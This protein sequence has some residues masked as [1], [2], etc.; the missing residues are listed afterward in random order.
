VADRPTQ[1]V[2]RVGAR[3]AAEP[4]EDAVL[5][6]AVFEVGREMQAA[7]CCLYDFSPTSELLTLR[8][9][10]S[11]DDDPD[12]KAL[13]G[14]SFASADRPSLFRAL[15]DR[16]IVETHVNDAGLSRELRDDLWS[17]LTVLVAPVASDGEPTGLL[18]AGE[19]SIRHFAAGELEIFEAL[20][21]LVAPA[22]RNARLFDREQD[23][24][25][26]LAA[27]LE[28]SR[29]VSS[30]V[31]LG[32][33]LETVSRKTAEALGV[34]RCRIYELDQASDALEQRADFVDP[35]YHGELP[36]PADADDPSS[37]VRRA[38]DSGEVA[39][40]LLVTRPVGPRGR[41]GRRKV[42]ELHQTRLALPLL[43][44][45]SP[46]GVIVFFEPRGGREFSVTELD[47]ARGLAEQAA[48]AI[49]NAHLYEHLQEQA[50]SDGLTGLANH[51]HFYERLHEEVA[52]AQR[53]G[54]PVSLLMIDIDDF[55]HFNDTFG[56]QVGD[57][58]LRLVGAI[59]RQRLRAKIDIAARY[60]GE[61]FAAILPNTAVAGAALAGARLAG[62]IASLA[63][64]ADEPPAEAHPEGAAAVGERLRENVESASG[65]PTTVLPA[66]I[67][68][69]VGVAELES[70]RN[71]DELVA[72]ADRALYEAKRAGKNRVCLA[73]Q[74]PA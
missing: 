35:S 9:A 7:S 13:I 1:I 68:V 39:S 34:V 24:N 36:D 23:H 30:T 2:A 63:E 38:L 20:A 55:K 43:F 42:P 14:A 58:A 32:E 46:V 19:K 5:A 41:F 26:H 48:A 37:V 3:I 4:Q 33:V 8:A 21:T 61:E 10:W 40:E 73:T 31:V 50:T 67:T 56:H 12:L 71:A 66:H 57:E 52:R 64:R 16:R 49:Q 72:A 44:G 59:L 51:R 70:G 45:G 54:L 28:A 60:G 17:D 27:L 69:S 18:V 74:A 53:Y 11:I 6:S 65:E 62:E 29:A 47:L 22:I 15:R 25:R